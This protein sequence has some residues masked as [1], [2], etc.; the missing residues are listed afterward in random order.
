M[1]KLTVVIQ[2]EI[3]KWLKAYAMDMSNDLESAELENGLWDLESFILTLDKN[4]KRILG[5]KSNA[6]EWNPI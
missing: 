4:Y 5:N 3:L 6:S 2:T 1:T